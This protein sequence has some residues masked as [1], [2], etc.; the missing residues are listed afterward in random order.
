[1]RHSISI[2][3]LLATVLARVAV[4]G[5]SVEYASQVDFSQ[6][7]SY[8]WSEGV[9][10]RDRSLDES[11]RRAVDRELLAKGL[12]KIDEEG[13]LLVRTR[14]RL[15]EEQRREVDILGERVVWEEGV[16]A[17]GSGGERMVEV[18]MGLIAVEM[19]DGHSKL[20]VWQGVL[21]AEASAEPG[22]PS[23]KRIDKLIRKMFRKY[24]PK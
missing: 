17:A 2:S 20:V 3:F 13:D 7:R 22:R 12:K 6:F 23:E 14:V 16:P 9:G 19:L 10:I 18:D 1:M 15:Q 24:P 11:L 8:S 5:V 4:A 21:G